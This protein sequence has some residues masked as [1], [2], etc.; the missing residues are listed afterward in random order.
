MGKLVLKSKHRILC[1]DS[2]KEADVQR[3]MNG[4]RAGMVFTDPPYGVGYDGGTTIREKL[5][6]DDTTDLY[7]PCCK[8]AFDFSTPDSPLYLWHAGIKGIAAAAAAAAAGYEIRCEIVWNKNLAQ[9][10]AL[11]SQYKQKHEP[12]Y[13]CFKHG[14]VVNWCGPKNE[15]TVWDVN[16]ASV[17]EFHPTQKP[18]ELALRAMT[19]HS[20]QTVLDLF[21]GSGATLIA[22]E[23]LGRR[24]FGIE[25]AP[26]YV[27]VVVA[28]WEKFT[29][30][31]AVLAKA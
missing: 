12:C 27:D 28:R 21:L 10:G 25:I 3:L 24:C 30:G 17:N 7:V 29:G 9:F 23:Q 14:K 8:M 19:N 16:R 18:V 4:E 11:S 6:G 5:A 2:T 26:R 15:V 13:Y 31:K 1:G 20:A 22:A